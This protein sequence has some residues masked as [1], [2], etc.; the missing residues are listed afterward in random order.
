M[1][2]KGVNVCIYG[3]NRSL[4]VTVHSIQD[5]ILRPLQSM[6]DEVHCH[7]AFNVTASGEFS[8]KR[9]GESLSRIADDQQDLLPGFQIQLVD[10][11]EFDAGFDLAGAL[12]PGDHYQ[13]DGG[14][15]LNMMRALHAL[16]KCYNSIPA[17]A[18]ESFPTIFVRPDLDII[19]DLDIEFLL[20]HSSGNSI[21]VPGWQFFGGVND[22]FSVAA[23]GH[24]SEAYAN[25]LDTV[26]QYLALTGRPFHSESYLFDVLNLKRLKVLPIVQAR[27]VRV[28]AGQ[29]FHP[30]T[31]Q[32]EHLPLAASAES[33]SLLTEQLMT[34]HRRLREAGERIA[35]FKD[36]Q[37]SLEQKA[38]G[39]QK[40]VESL[41]QML[42]EFKRKVRRL[43]N[44][45]RNSS[46]V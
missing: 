35:V 6:V 15:V 42:Q 25:R 11:D 8:S 38:E 40:N 22:R 43:R 3:L 19:D 7:A 31:I 4:G 12:A 16:K 2:F 24:A 5:K 20:S 32:L 45:L 44:K 30:E 46:N 9:S 26:F 23:A 29:A 27:F 10:Q 17:H 34:M 39:L 1:R 33:W 21:V 36:S 37:A 13:D 18:R 41:E 14:S 28:R